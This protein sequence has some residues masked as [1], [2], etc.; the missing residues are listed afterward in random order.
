[1]SAPRRK[2]KPRRTPA[3]TPTVVSAPTTAAEVARALTRPPS[4]DPPIY[5]DLRLE[6]AERIRQTGEARGI[7]HT[8][9]HRDNT[10]GGA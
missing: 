2:P 10:E 7:T 4:G 9:Q 6:F 1:M 8:P 3:T 5:R